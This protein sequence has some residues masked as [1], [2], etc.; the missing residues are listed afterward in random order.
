MSPA[1]GAG[2]HRTPFKVGDRV[3]YYIP[4]GGIGNADLDGRSG[5]VIYID[6][7]RAPI[8]IRL[9]EPYLD[10]VNETS[11]ELNGKRI[12]IPNCWFCQ[13]QNLVKLNGLD[14]STHPEIWMDPASWRA[15]R[16]KSE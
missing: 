7:T 8:T 13:T 4:H 15:Q 10:A 6:S 3:R 12:H 14:R 9:D 1:S 16:T 11:V 5:V 2:K